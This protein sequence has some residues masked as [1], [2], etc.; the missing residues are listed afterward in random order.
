M[1]SST[2]TTAARRLA[3]TAGPR[4]AATLDTLALRAKGS[5]PR[6]QQRELLIREAAAREFCAHGYGGASVQNIADALQ[7]NKATLYHYVRSKEELLVGLFEFAH[8]EIMATMAQVAALQADPAVRL[9]TYLKLRLLSYL[10]DQDIAKVVFSE[11]RNLSP[12]LL[13]EQRQRR[14]RYDTFVRE[15]IREGQQSKHFDRRWD[16][17]LAAR[18]VIGA[19]NDVPAWFRP[20]G[21]RSARAVAELY[22]EFAIATL[23]AGPS[24]AASR[25][26]RLPGNAGA[27]RPTRTRRARA[28]L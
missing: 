19:I 23:A 1:N 3:R 15:L 22:G 17:T 24:G 4:R 2:P 26:D 20:E 27:P 12:T 6:R 11:Y 16:P 7:I 21:R 25:D 10:A 28:K 9:R 8:A 14:R 18:Y 13:E 5:L